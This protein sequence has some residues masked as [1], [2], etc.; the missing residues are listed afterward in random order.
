M[1]EHIK[2]LLLCMNNMV[3]LLFTRLIMTQPG[4]WSFGPMFSWRFM[5]MCYKT[6]PAKRKACQWSGS[7]EDI[8]F[9]SSPCQHEHWSKPW[10]FGWYKGSI[11]LLLPSIYRD[12]CILKLGGGFKYV[13]CSC[14][15]GDSWS[16]L[17]SIFVQNGLVQPPTRKPWWG[18]LWR[19]LFPWLRQI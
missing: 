16:N 4:S 7:S 2:C 8:L 15:P 11:I 5:R 1:S 18:S 14:L 3:V 13:L 17:T 12:Y 19:N 10:L 9:S 6:L